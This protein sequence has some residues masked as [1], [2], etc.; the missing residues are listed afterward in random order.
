MMIDALTTRVVRAEEEMA[1]AGMQASGRI[2]SALVVLFLLFDGITEAM[3]VGRTFSARG[4]AARV[5]AAAN[6]R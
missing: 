6:L 2:I 5:D 1:Q 4:A 3:K